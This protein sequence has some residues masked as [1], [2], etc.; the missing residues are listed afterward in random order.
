MSP[1]PLDTPK[2]GMNAIAAFFV[3]FVCLY[4]GYAC[5]SLNLESF[6]SVSFSVCFVY[7]V[8]GYNLTTEYTEFTEGR[9]KMREC[10]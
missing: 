6:F 10:L 9:E 5:D 7:S 2:E 8:V 3:L 4:V 1:Q